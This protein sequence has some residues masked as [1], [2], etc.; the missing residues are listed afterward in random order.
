MRVLKFGGTS[1][2]N[3]RRVRESARIALNT[4]GTNVIVVSASGGVTNLLIDAARAAARHDRDAVASAVAEIHARHENVLS[5]I[6][7]DQLRATASGAVNQIHGSLTSTLDEVFTQGQL[8]PKLSDKV[9]SHGE[10]AM[11]LMM[12]AM[13]RDMGTPAEP[14]F[15]DTVI[16]TDGRHSAAR[17]DREQTRAAA[18]SKILPLLQSGTTAVA[19]GFIGFG[20]DGATTTLGRSGSDYSATLLGAALDAEEVQIWTDVPGVLSADPRK[21]PAARVISEISYDEAQELAHFGA[22]VLHPRTI[23]PA[24]AQNIPVRILSTFQPTNSGTVVTSRA[25]AQGI[26]AT[27]ALKGLTLL[28]LDVPELEDLAPAASVIFRVLHEQRVEILTV[29]QS[30]SRRRM[31]FIVDTVGGGCEMLTAQITAALDDIEADISCSDN[32]AVV[33][34]VGDGAANLPSSLAR[35]LAVLHRAGIEV[36]A[37]NQQNSNAAM[38]VVVPEDVS[39]H[40]VQV[41]HDAF[42][43]PSR[44]SNRSASRRRSDLL[45]ES[46]RVG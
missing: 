28:T 41:V 31:S 15:T 21:V 12:A 27:T 34:A 45:G 17:P 23:R 38:V 7:E 44:R 13:V 32:V 22:K 16:A 42:I 36:L 8:S 11:A 39:D 46:L 35:M 26:K 1:V 18:A 24:V 2:G 40:A 5:G 43:G 29:S 19:T 20:P 33:A 6:G 9:V 25:L 4:P 14:V 3:A 10:K 37:T 30:S